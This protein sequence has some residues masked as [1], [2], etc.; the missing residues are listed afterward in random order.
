MVRG[1]NGGTESSGGGPANCAPE[2]LV[3]EGSALWHQSEGQ[4]HRAR[5]SLSD[6]DVVRPQ[7]TLP[8]RIQC[9]SGDLVIVTANDWSER[10]RFDRGFSVPAGDPAGELGEEIRH[11]DVGVRP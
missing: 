3:V 5:A 1:S 9:F 4:A 6:D 11:L 10:H 2:G 8:S 7:E